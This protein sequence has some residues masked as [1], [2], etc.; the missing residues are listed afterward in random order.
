M[1]MAPPF[2][3]EVLLKKMHPMKLELEFSL[4]TAPPSLLASEALKLNM[5]FTT[6]GLLFRL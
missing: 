4:Y 3:V 5:Q 1:A 2:L 6:L